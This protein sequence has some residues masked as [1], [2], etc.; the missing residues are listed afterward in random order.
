MGNLEAQRKS[1]AEI[2]QVAAPANSGIKEA[3]LSVLREN[4]VPPEHVAR[5]YE[6]IALP[7]DKGQTVSQPSTIAIM[8]GLLDVKDGMNALEVGCGSGYVLALLS[9]LVGKSGKV[10]GIDFH[11]EL[12][13]KSLE[14]LKK[15]KI[16]NVEVQ[17][18]DGAEGWSEKAPFDRILVSCACPFIPK[19]L[20]SELKEGGIIVAPVGDQWSQQLEVLRKIKEKPLRKISEHGMFVFVPLRGR[21]GFL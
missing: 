6:D 14:N 11:K 8:L 2:I 3:F 5:A 12:A 7:N 13:Q 1:L 16:L 18:G 19:E 17:A 15:E 21:H 4:F 20:F 10:Y 9:K